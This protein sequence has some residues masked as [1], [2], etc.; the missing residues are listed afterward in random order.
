[1]TRFI[2]PGWRVLALPDYRRLW[3]AHAGSVIGD[4]FHAIAITWLVFDTLGGG[5]QALAVLGI[6]NVVPALALGILSGTIVD[7]VDRRRLMV[8]TDLVRAALVGALAVLVATGQARIPVVIAIGIALLLA[9]AAFFALGVADA[10]LNAAY[11]ALLQT[12]VPPDMRGRT[13]ATFSTAM[14]LTTPVSLAV[15]G[16]LATVAGPVLLIAISGVGLMGVG[17]TSFAASLREGRA[18]RSAAS[19]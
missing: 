12:T 14:N 6:A 19:A 13:F 16:A 10:V 8:A 17:A 18:L 3:L 1:M 2:P 9:A 4:G 7:R 15:T 5:P 11:A